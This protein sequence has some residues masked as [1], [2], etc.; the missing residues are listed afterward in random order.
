MK[1]NIFLFI[2]VCLAIF[3][4]SCKENSAE[5]QRENELKKL[6]EYIRA[7]YSGPDTEKKP[8]GLYFTLLSEGTGD[9]IKMGDRVQIFHETMTL[10]SLFVARTGH[11]E[12]LELIVL[13][14]TE[15][16]TSATNVIDLRGLHEGLTYMKKGSKARLI[17][18]S[19]LGFGQFGTTGVGGFT[20]LVM[21]VEVYK[22]Y[23][24]QLPEEG[25][26]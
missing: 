7:F 22:V 25:G 17:F 16:A 18:D 1:R 10:D 12:P 15:L 8:S 23:P 19:A 3:S 2:G 11:H 4:Y 9:S 5:K 14:P 26:N 13:P 21:D 20:S 6:N 24:A